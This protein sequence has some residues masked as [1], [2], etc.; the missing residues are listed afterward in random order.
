MRTLCL[1]LILV[2][3]LY[4]VWAELIDVRP[5]AL[6]RSAPA[7]A[8]APARIVLAREATKQPAEST[9]PEEEVEQAP[10]QDVAPPSV[11]PLAKAA[12]AEGGA[13]LD[14]LS[15]SSIGPFPD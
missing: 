14:S 8:N 13:Q 5:S 12:P 11:E 7:V 4:L 6:E 15:C 9:P 10:L 2:N 1:V 3:A